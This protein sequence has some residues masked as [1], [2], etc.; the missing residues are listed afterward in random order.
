MT[1]AVV[2][3]LGRCLNFF[4]RQRTRQSWSLNGSTPASGDNPRV[5]VEVSLPPVR[6]FEKPCSGPTV[7]QNIGPGY[8]WAPIVERSLS[9][10]RA[11]QVPR[12]RVDN[13]DEAVCDCT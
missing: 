8:G 2:L 1:R 5:R 12:S 13:R 6:A 11:E 7:S 3:Y 9:G 10:I 4:R